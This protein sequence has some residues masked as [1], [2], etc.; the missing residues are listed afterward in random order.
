MLSIDNRVLNSEGLSVEY[1]DGIVVAGI[2]RYLRRGLVLY[3]FCVARVKR[4][5]IGTG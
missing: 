1:L 5:S 2:F 3:E 4:L